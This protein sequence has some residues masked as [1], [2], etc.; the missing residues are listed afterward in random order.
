MDSKTPKKYRVGVTWR[1]ILIGL[2]LIPINSYWIFMS[3]IIRYKGH[4]TTISL[5][6]SSIFSLLL[7]I[8]LNSAIRRLKPSWTFS[9]GELV[10]IYVMLNIGAALVG[11]DS[12]QILVSMM[13]YAGH[14]ATPSNNWHKLFADNLPGWLVIK[15]VV[16][17]KHFY[18]GGQSF[19][20][21]VNYGPWIRPVLWWSA[22][23]IVMGG[24]FLCLN[25]LL[26]KQWTERE[27]LSYPLVQLPL[28]MTAEGAPLFKE[29][30][31]WYGFFI[32]A[33]I[34]IW[35]GLSVL[36]PSIPSLPIKLEDQS[37]M[38]TT[39]PWNSIGWLPVQFYPFGIGLGM[40]LPVDLLFSC[41]FFFWIWKLERVL[42]AVLGF[43]TVPNMP[44]TG[45]QSFG[46]YMGICVFSILISRKHFIN[47]FKHFLGLKTDIDDS[48]EPISYKAAMWFLVAGAIFL[49]AFSRKAGMSGLL[50]VPFFVIFFAMSIAI[51][52]M[53]AELGPPAHDLHAAGPDAILPNVL[54]PKALDTQDLS[55]FSLYFWFN[56][57]Y[58]CHEMPF[59][60]EG[61]KM[62]ERTRSSYRGLFIAIALATVFGTFVAFWVI[63]T[64]LY[65]HGAASSN[66]GPPNVP[67][68][69]GT[70]PWSRLEGWTNMPKPSD[71]NRGMAIGVGFAITLILNSLRMRLGW[72]PFHPVGYAVSSSWAMSLLWAPMFIAWLTK[73]LILRYGGLRLYR[74]ALPFFLGVIL[75]ECVIGSFW[76]LWGIIFRLPIYAFWP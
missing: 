52:R 12:I 20:D 39:R 4:P 54:G 75:G 15:D 18:A 9:Q 71:A 64:L 38:F 49:I 30:L 1:A 68:I 25:V 43:D 48:Q 50:I 28:D 31:L 74:R 19:C 57:A 63:L 5:F 27:K 8:L 3:E 60:L 16:S 11:H 76:T 37:R 46:A 59:Q 70:E 36:Y 65:K 41:W 14:F 45:E 2:L 7:L 23:I 13:P 44:F 61:F 73:L 55:V 32:V 34:D 67:L 58:R 40:L 24:M 66:I 21:P 51:T 42:V 47:L 22:F 69:F 6:Y 26:R 17:T 10:T 35:Q 53:R 72:F 56:R 62:A 29:R 33:A